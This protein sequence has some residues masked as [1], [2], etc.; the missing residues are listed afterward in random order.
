MSTRA[1]SS[2]SSPIIDPPSDLGRAN[3]LK[4]LEFIGSQIAENT[5][6]LK[7]IADQGE[8][9]TITQLKRDPEFGRATYADTQIRQQTDELASALTPEGKVR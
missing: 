6:Q 5:V 3:L 4:A 9:V 2:K 1:Q 7:R 8:P